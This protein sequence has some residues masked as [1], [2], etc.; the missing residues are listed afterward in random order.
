MYL[1]FLNAVTPLPIVPRSRSSAR[2]RRYGVR[3]NINSTSDPSREDEIAAKIANLRK[4][5]RLQS[6]RSTSESST[7]DRAESPREDSYDTNISAA[8]VSFNDLPDWK[9]E[10]VLKDQISQAEAFLNPSSLEEKSPSSDADG[11][12][13]KPRVSTWGVYPRPDNI[14][15]TYGGGKNIKQG[16]VDLNSESAKKRDQAVAEKLAAYRAARGIDIKREEEHRQEIEAALENANR[17]S[18]RS[19]PYEAIRT[20]E[21][22][23]DYISDRS[24]LGGTVYLSLA[25]AYDSVGRREDAREIYAKLRR[26]AFPEICGKAKQLLQGFEAMDMLK[27]S[28][29]AKDRGFRV[30]KY[31]LPDVSEQ[32]ERR[33]ETAVGVSTEPSEKLDMRTNILLA[34]LFLGPLAFVLFLLA[35]LNR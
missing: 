30:T 26:S 7:L 18:S 33:Y 24:R 21:G 29:E 23:L 13:Y 1:A 27:I 32:L 16:G 15:R 17:L 25:L 19:Q 28:D 2:C 12:K 4:Q 9:K 6:Q 3:A 11:E 20:L 35:P 31:T 8:P 34:A 5:K 10:E 14:S 22:V